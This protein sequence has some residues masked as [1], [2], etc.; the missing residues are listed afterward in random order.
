MA[1]NTYKDK[2]RL[3]GYIGEDDSYQCLFCGPDIGWVMNAGADVWNNFLNPL[4]GY[5]DQITKVLV[6]DSGSDEFI[7]ELK[8][9]EKG[10]NHWLWTSRKE[11][12]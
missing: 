7:L 2:Y 6:Q 12:Y 9:G 8:K 11:N 3:V 4:C 10:C 5:Q 1:N